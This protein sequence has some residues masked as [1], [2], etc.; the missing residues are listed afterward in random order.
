MFAIGDRWVMRTT[1]VVM[2]QAIE[3]YE[4]RVKAVSGVAS[5]L[6]ELFA[7]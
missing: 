1:D 7:P 4:Y 6:T 3:I 5:N 2:N